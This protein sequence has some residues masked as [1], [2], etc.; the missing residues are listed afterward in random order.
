M[1]FTRPS[2]RA[3]TVAATATA[4]VVAFALP[5]AAHITINPDTAEPGGY[6][7]FNVRVPNEE[8]D[9]DT[10]KVEL[11]LPTDHPIAS[12]SV[13]PTPGWAVEPVKTRLPKPVT[14]KDGTTL[15]EAVTRITWSG[16]K[17]KP[18]EFQ[19]FWISLGPLPTDTGTLYFTALQ[20]YTDENG[21]TKVV[22]WE[23]IPKGGGHHAHGGE[24]PEH[25]APSVTLAKP[26]AAHAIPMNHDES[27]PTGT[28]LGAAGLI[29]AIAALA[30]AVLALRRSGRADGSDRTYGSGKA[31]RPG[32]A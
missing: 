20:T 25:P 7:A 13:Q 27:T 1:K 17:I 23:E 24:E 26:A 22:R 29:I 5:A 31:A 28:I 15:T 10:T 11:Q 8:P 16:G 14:T 4:L 30:A 6:S 32:N 18:G 21:D 9:A 3:L 12:V 19:Q 2:R